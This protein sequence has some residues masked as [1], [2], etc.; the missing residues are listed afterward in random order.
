MSS[1]WGLLLRN[2]LWV[3]VSLVLALV[4]K[5]QRRSRWDPRSCPVDLRG[6]TA[7]V[8]GANTGIGFHIALDLA[9]RGA[10]VV[11][12]CRCPVK[13]GEARDQ[14]QVQ[15]GNLEVEVR[16]LDLSDMRSIRAF[17]AEFNR[18]EAELHILVNNAGVSG[19]PRKMT[20][21]GFDLTFATNHLGPFLLTNLL[22]DLLKSSAP[23]RIVIL[24]SS[25]HSKGTID[26]SHFRGENLVY[27]ADRV[28]NNTKLHNV[29]WSRE[30]ALRLQG[31]GVCVNSVHPGYVMTDVL[32]HYPLRIKFIF[33]LIGFFFF[34]RPE[35]G[36][37]A[38]LFC[39]MSEEME[40]VSGKYVDSDCSLSLPSATARDAALGRTGF[41]TCHK[42]TANL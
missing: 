13:G 9:R 32:R 36:A 31:S 18:E 38:P 35:D 40:G 4:V 25:N 24:A 6:K 34:K 19:L 16:T 20:A 21:D 22:L 2:P 27:R 33:N 29:M 12:A 26:F 41:D 3:V 42:L 30:L 37:V 28:Y 17:A 7:L 39:A 11:L 23:S 14:I 10:R 8:T 5:V 1:W 15:S